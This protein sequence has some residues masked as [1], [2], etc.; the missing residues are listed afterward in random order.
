MNFTGRSQGTWMKKGYSFVPYR[1]SLTVVVRTFVR[2]LT[3]SNSKSKELSGVTIVHCTVQEPFPGTV[4]TVLYKLYQ[5]SP[6]KFFD[7][8][9]F[10]PDRNQFEL[11]LTVRTVQIPG[12]V[13]QS[14][15]VESQRVLHRVLSTEIQNLV[16]LNK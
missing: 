16:R 13:V 15:R 1:K 4:R 11:L 6:T 5:V 7:R 3:K 14:Q 10:I 2:T 8:R 12:E 9:A